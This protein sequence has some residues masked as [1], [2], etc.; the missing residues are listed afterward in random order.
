MIRARD[1][2]LDQVLNQSL[3]ATQSLFDNVCFVILG[4]RLV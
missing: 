3:D 1:Q 4:C 2:L